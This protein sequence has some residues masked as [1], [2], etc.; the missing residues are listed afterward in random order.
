MRM[1]LHRGGYRD[2]EEIDLDELFTGN[3]RVIT[4]AHRWDGMAWR[5]VEESK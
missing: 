3:L 1:A 5:P 4:K 2:D